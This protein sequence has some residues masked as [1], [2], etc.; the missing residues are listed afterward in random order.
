MIYSSRAE[1]EM[2]FGTFMLCTSR[3]ES[4]MC[5]KERCMCIVYEERERERK[6]SAISVALVKLHV[7]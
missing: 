4:D 7:T 2:E 5:C 1:R 3:R 6:F